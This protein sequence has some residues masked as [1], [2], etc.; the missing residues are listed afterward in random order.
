LAGVLLFSAQA[1][2]SLSEFSFS[3]AFGHFEG[4]E[5]IAI[6]ES[7]GDVY[8]Y[9]YP[10]GTINKFDADGNPVDFS[11]LASNQITGVGSVA[12]GEAEL[13]VDNSSGPASGDIYL[14]GGSGVQI[15]GSDGGKL[16]EL[17]E[18]GG[19]PWGEVACGVAVDGTGHVYVGL[20]PS[21]INEYTPTAEAVTNSDYTASL[22]GLNE[23]CNVAAGPDG[24]VYVDSWSSTR[25]GPIAKFDGIQSSGGEQVVAHAGGTLAVANSPSAELFASGIAKTFV[26]R[27][28]EILQYDPSGNQLSTFGAVESSV[29]DV[30]A[31]NAKNGKLYVYNANSEG[32]EGRKVEIWQGVITPQVRTTQATSLDAAGSATLSGS[33]NP[34]GVSVESCAFQYGL[35]VSYGS[36]SACAQA[37]PLTGDSELPVSTSVSGV[38]LNQTYHYRLSTTDEHG[39]VDGADR[40]FTI[41]VLPTVEDQSPVVSAITRASAELTG[42]IDP[43]QG[44]TRYHFEYGPSENYGDTTPVLHTGGG[45]VGDTT[46]SQQLGELLPETTYHYRL[47]AINIAGTAVGADHTFTTGASTLPTAVTGGSSGVAENTATVAGAVN[48]NG[49]PT[50]YGFEVGTS[51]DYGPPTGLGAVG[52]GAGEVPVSRALSGLLPGTTYHYRLTATNLDGTSYGADQTFTTG[53]FANAFAT[54][55]AALPFVGVP[56]VAFP[57]E[58]PGSSPTTPKAL[59]RAQKLAAALKACHKKAKGKRAGCEKQARKKYGIAKQ[60]SRKE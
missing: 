7:T 49:L 35:S 14:A 56:A 4:A 21:N 9:N 28:N 48:T 8:V 53:V 39:A 45:I 43:E 17:T 34:E 19:R 51:T 52:A 22:T 33:V 54:P 30:V 59:T 13:A 23:V 32:A 60:K 16:G 2:A 27:G 3:S 25:N 41:L 29:Y 31:I 11:A 6:D 47:V 38:M 12:G 55:P 37:T 58:S 44:D 15:Y 1:G 26:G 20:Y 10:D 24:S 42:T 5:G 18:V 40:T 36:V 50:T 46:V 57:L